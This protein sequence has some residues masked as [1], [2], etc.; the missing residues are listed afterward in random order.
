ML[1]D[2]KG[3]ENGTIVKEYNEGQTYM[4]EDSL[5]GVFV[6]NDWAAEMDTPESLEQERKDKINALGKELNELVK[7]CFLSELDSVQMAENISKLEE[8][9]IV[10]ADFQ[11][12]FETA[13]KMKEKGIKDAKKSLVILNKKT[14]DSSK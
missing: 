3:S 9:E 6:E 2:Q 5:A 4:M 11:E 1:R 12:K 10:E 13:T 8:Y 7:K 14:T